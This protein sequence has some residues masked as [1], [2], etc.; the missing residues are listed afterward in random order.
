MATSTVLAAILRDAA[1]RAALSM[2]VEMAVKADRAAPEA[3]FCR[4][5]HW[6]KISLN[7]LCD[8]S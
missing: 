7:P 3:I 1:L 8:A 4:F 5:W 2:T 6:Q